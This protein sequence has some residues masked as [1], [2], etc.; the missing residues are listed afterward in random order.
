MSPARVAVVP[1]NRLGKAGDAYT[2]EVPA[3]L[4]GTLAEG[5]LVAMPF[6]NRSTTGVVT[7]LDPDIGPGSLREIIGIADDRPVLLPHHLELARWI[8]GEYLAPLADVVRSMLP[9]AVK[10][11]RARPTERVAVLTDSGRE[12]VADPSSLVRA[13]RRLAVLQAIAGN[14]SEQ[15]RALGTLDASSALIRAMTAAGLIEIQ[16]RLTDRNS[17]VDRPRPAPSS[18]TLSPAQQVAVD[19]IL[20]RRDD[21]AVLLL[22]GVTGS[23]KTEVYMTVIANAIN[24]GRQAIVLVPEI[25]LT[26]QTIRRFQERFPGRVVAAHSA[27]S[28][29]QRAED[30]LKLRDGLADIVVGPRSAIFAPLDRLGVI[31]VDEEHDTSYKQGESPRY[32]A[33]DVAIRLGLRLSVPVILGSATPDVCSY[34]AARK[35]RFTLLDLPDRPTW[36]HDGSASLPRA[37]PAVELIDLRHELKAGSKGIFSRALTSAL[38]DTLRGGSQAMLFINRRGAATAVVCRDC[39]YVVHCPRCD[40]PMTYHSASARMIC[41]RCD[42]RERPPAVCPAC[43]GSRIRYLGAGTQRI[44]E[45]TQRL[46][47]AAR[48]LRWDRDTVGARGSHEQIA[49]RFAA[50]EADVLVGT[51]MI[52]KGHDFPNVTLVGV[53]LADIGLHMPDFR[54]AERTFQL[55]TQVAG[56]AGRA[57]LASRVIVQTYSPEHFALQAAQSHDYWSFYRQEMRFR[58]DA[59]YPP[60]VRMARLIFRGPAFDRVRQ[61]AHECRDRIVSRASGLGLEDVH[62]VGPAPSYV[63]R[64]NNTHY[65]HLVVACEAV[66]ELVAPEA[67][68]DLSIDIDPMDLL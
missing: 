63:S 16:D 18:F 3:A 32:H 30:W 11:G 51:Q 24:R 60:F 48:V 23:G 45:E 52:A 46:F 56:R 42:R 66:H 28:D 47:P 19:A 43:A 41:H 10:S 40:A 2:Y 68:A 49:S 59:R 26:P 14:G 61:S 8:A 54:A 22:H 27:L 35:G 34:Y 13:P 62:L 65:W 20:A 64:V 39:G 4:R 53:V 44:V 67:G 12:A 55:M 6:R 1:L 37:M 21:P 50:R 9:A 29:T 7:Q 31:I 17:E 36:T 58:L 15:G 38:E 57:D 33:R 5:H 25:G